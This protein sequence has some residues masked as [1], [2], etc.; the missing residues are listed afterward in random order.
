MRMNTENKREIEQEALSRAI[1]NETFSNYPAI[2]EGFAAKGIPEAE[3]KPRENVFSY[4]AWR[5]LGRQVK[6]GE[7]GVAICTYIHGSKKDKDGKTEAF[8]FPRTVTVFHRTQTEP[9]KN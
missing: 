8:S 9:I 4:H 5:A 6:R 1:Q 2:F 3:I 7:H